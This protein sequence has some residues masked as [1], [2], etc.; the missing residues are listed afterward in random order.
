MQIYHE[1][2]S[3]YLCVMSEE[4]LQNESAENNEELYERFQIVIDRG[5]DP[6]RIDKFLTQR[7]E[8]ASRNKLQQAINLGMV[9][10]NG[11]EVRP[12]YKVKPSD[13]V[14]VY[15]DLSPEETDVIAEKM[16]LPITYEDED[17]IIFNKPAGMVVHPGSGNYSGTLLNGVAWYLKEKLPGFSEDQLPRFG[18]VHR[19]DKN[20]SGLLVLAKSDQAMRQLAKQFFDHTVKRE[21]LALVWG[22]MEKDEGTIIAHVG[23]HLRFRK[24]FDAYPEGDHG[25]EAI[26]HYKVIERFRY[27]TLVRCILETGRTHQIRVHMKHIG[28]P[29]FSD[30]FYGGDRIV[31]GT[32]FTKYKQFVENCFAICPR[33]ALHAKTLGFIHPRSGKQ[34]NFDSELPADM[35]GV[36]EKWRE[37]VK[38]E[39]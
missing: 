2:P 38:V 36:I 22:D 23:R 35:S 27:V 17:L 30:D 37:Y 32:V 6:V 26:T 9:L 34:M 39:R 19:I 25:K 10:V 31:K 21:Y 33:Q 12:N 28:H 18:L 15:S 5:Q 20:T 24:L 4:I 29:L 13:Q 1:N 8:N 7:L 14:T 11:K 16:E 3:V